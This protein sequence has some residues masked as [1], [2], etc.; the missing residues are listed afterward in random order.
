MSCRILVVDDEE[1]IRYTFREFLTDAGFQVDTAESLT[2]AAAMVGDTD[3]DAIFLDILL[4]RENG[5]NLLK[6]MREQSPNCPVTMVTGSPEIKTA[7]E[8]VRH[9]AFDYLVKPLTQ[10]ELVRQAHRAV[11]YK[12][13]IDQKERYQE[14]LRAVFEGVREGLLVFT[15]ELR[16]IEMN[17]S[18]MQMLHCDTTCLGQELDKLAHKDG[19]SI[20]MAVQGLIESRFEGELYMLQIPSATGKDICISINIS[21]LTTAKGQDADLVVVL[22]DESQPVT[23]LSAK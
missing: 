5:L 2:E 14:R 12:S 20:L 3:Y 10:D 15:A 17:Y 19:N 11:A 21:P 22:R 4:G 13:A 18:A 23:E 6:V 9:G 16:L 8:A 1:A 7:A